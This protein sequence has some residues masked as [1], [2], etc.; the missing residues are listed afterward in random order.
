MAISSWS[1]L[2]LP[3]FCKSPKMLFHL[4][5]GLSLSLLSLPVSGTPGTGLNESEIQW[6]KL[7]YE[8]DLP[9]E[10]LA[11][12]YGESEI[13]NLKSLIQA[14]QIGPPN[15]ENTREDGTYGLSLTWMLNARDRWLNNFSW[16]DTQRRLNRHPHFRA[17]VSDPE[18]QF[19][20]SIHFMALFS[21]RTDAIPLIMFH[22]WPGSFLEFVELFD[23]VKSRFT[24][25]A[26]PYHLIVPSLPGFPL[27]Q[28]LPFESDFGPLD[29]ARIMTRL[30]HGLGFGDGYVVQG[31]DL[32][33]TIAMAV[34]GSDEGCKAC[35][36]NF[37]PI[38]MAPEGAETNLTA[39][40][41]ADLE[42]G[43]AYMQ[44]HFGYAAE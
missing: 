23:L 18:T 24:P 3:N 12:N 26:N 7:P 6:S 28:P 30:I 37:L 11:I 36:V 44:N 16:P 20:Y 41:A 9:V 42:K 43:R 1:I 29:A 2:L 39:Q 27:S 34:A 19:K 8:P 17:T 5:V 14:S 32:G 21:E 33:A 10:P 38:T 13:Q 35:H 31:G 15:F 40:E 22:G 25:A 4:L